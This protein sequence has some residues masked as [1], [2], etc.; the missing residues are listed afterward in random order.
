MHNGRKKTTKPFYGEKSVELRWAQYP[1]AF[2]QGSDMVWALARV[3]FYANPEF[4]STSTLNILVMDSFNNGKQVSTEASV[5]FGLD[6]WIPSGPE[7]GMD[8]TFWDMK[9]STV[10]GPLECAVRA[11]RLPVS[12]RVSSTS[13]CT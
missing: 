13:R 10:G 12:E 4:K 8:L 5:D 3:E 9:K 1:K 6:H 2:P 11:T 7:A